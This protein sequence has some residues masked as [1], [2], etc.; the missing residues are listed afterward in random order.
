MLLQCGLVVG[1]GTGGLARLLQPRNRRRCKAGHRRRGSHLG[2]WIEGLL[3]VQ[4]V[5]KLL[6]PL[7]IAGRA[8]CIVDVGWIAGIGDAPVAKPGRIAP[9]GWIDVGVDRNRAGEA[10]EQAAGGRHRRGA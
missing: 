2:R 3:R 5:Q 4:L 6:Q 8:G 7:R 1:V 9:L 10:H